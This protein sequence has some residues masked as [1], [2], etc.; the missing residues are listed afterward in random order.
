MGRL[1]HI[2][3]SA[4]C[5]PFLK[6]WASQASCFPGEIVSI[7]IRVKLLAHSMLLMKFLKTGLTTLTNIEYALREVCASEIEGTCS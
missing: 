4:F 1:Y 6:A 2:H 3:F 5:L 7:Y